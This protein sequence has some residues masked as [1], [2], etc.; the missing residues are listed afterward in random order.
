M[1]A[2]GICKW[3]RVRNLPPNMPQGRN[4]RA[5]PGFAAVTPE[6]KLRCLNLLKR[7]ISPRLISR[8]MNVS[9]KSAER[10][11]T[12]MLRDQP[13]LRRPGTAR[14]NPRRLPSGRLY[15]KLGPDRRV[16]AFVLYADGRNDS[17]IAKDLGLSPQRIWEWRA[18]LAL[19]PVEGA[20]RHRST[21]AR[22]KPAGPPISPLSNPLYLHI[23]T[24]IGRGLAPDIA[25]DVVSD[26][27]LA[28]ASGQLTVDQIVSQAPQFRSRVVADYASQFG[29]RSLDE[30]IGNSHGFRMIDMIR[31]DRSTSW[32]E[33][34]GAT[35]W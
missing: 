7:G 16:R 17:E 6:L 12:Q 32:L 4:G 8:E 23:L 1:R 5:A 14:K 31:D 30:E 28:V 2:K 27:C 13:D 33:E 20:Q 10:W 21:K 19:P 35:A 29:P 22:A 25:D 15:R 34:M 24:S 26:M 3:R 11:R 18:A 9:E